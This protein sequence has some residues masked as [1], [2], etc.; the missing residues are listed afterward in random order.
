MNRETPRFGRVDALILAA[1]IAGAT[2]LATSDPKLVEATLGLADTQAQ[3]EADSLRAKARP[4]YREPP[5]VARLERVRRAVVDAGGWVLPCLT[6]GVAAATFRHR[7]CWSRRALRRVGVLTSA[8]AGIIV[9]WLFL[10][11]LAFRWAWPYGYGSGHLPLGFV[12]FYTV[13]T[14]A[15]LATTALW[16]VLAIGGR[17]KGVPEWPDRLGRAVG[18]AWVAYAVLGVL[19]QYAGLVAYHPDGTRG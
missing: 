2:W 4:D 19:L 10:G 15:S 12:L 16:G 17:W 7:E 11:D 5:P 14:D 8:I 18:W 9:A 3:L 1:S 6:L 13:G